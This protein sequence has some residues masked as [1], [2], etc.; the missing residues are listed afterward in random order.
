MLTTTAPER[1]ENLNLMKWLVKIDNQNGNQPKVWHPLEAHKQIFPSCVTNLVQIV[2]RQS[3]A[4]QYK[5][6]HRWKVH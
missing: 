5:K 3:R 1:A 2:R 6:Y 4:K